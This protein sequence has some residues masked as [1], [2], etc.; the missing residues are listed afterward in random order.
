MNPNR[1]AAAVIRSSG[2]LRLNATV[3]KRR[4]F[5]AKRPAAM[6]VT[7]HVVDVVTNAEDE[8]GRK[9]LLASGPCHRVRIISRGQSQP[10]TCNK[11]TCPRGMA[12]RTAPAGQTK[13]CS[14]RLQSRRF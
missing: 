11:R 5:R 13:Q 6:V 8:A 10:A 7:K 4:D 3:G 1:S 12:N 14:P 2:Y 9:V